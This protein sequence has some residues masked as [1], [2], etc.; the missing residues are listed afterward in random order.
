[1]R[2]SSAILVVLVL[3]MSG[4]VSWAQ[5]GAIPRGGLSLSAELDVQRILL[6]EDL[7]RY[8]R[9]TSKRSDLT[10]RLAA[11]YRALD[12]AV[13]DEGG[14]S[15]EEV[16]TL[17]EQVGEVEAERAELLTTQRLLIDRI[18]ERRRA[19]GLIEERL[20]AMP[21]NQSGL[22]GALVGTW[23]VIFLP[24]QQRGTFTF[25]QTGT[26]INGTYSLDG[27]WTGSL[28]GTLINRKVYMVR[29]DSKKGRMMELEGFLAGDGFGIRGTWL[30]YE[31]I[32]GDGARGQW[33][34]EKRDSDN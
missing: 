5:E 22:A 27:G 11:L 23:D 25:S 31:V 12:T 16:E 10:G 19:I 8:D 20:A 29:I 14:G 21:D 3:S 6:S 7:E 17:T 34:A 30:S 15:L 4:L 24:A 26:L 1:M 28:Q 9:L 32:G 2:H 18:R 33:S 13:Q